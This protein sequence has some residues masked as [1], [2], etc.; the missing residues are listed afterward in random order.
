MK[1]TVATDTMTCQVCGRTIKASKG[2]IAHHGYTRP[3]QQGWQSASCL[4]ARYVPYEVSC[5]RLKE[6]AE[7]VRNYIVR[8]EE[9]LADFIA[10]PPE[11]LMV[12]ERVSSWKSPEDVTYHKPEGFTLK[13]LQYL[14]RRTYEDA[15]DDR[16]RG[17]EQSIKGA[18][19]D[20]VV[21]G[22]RI[23]EWKESK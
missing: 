9:T 17:Y 4:G 16:K 21:M 6:V 13:S 22:Q 14:R 3:Y 18:K 12:A 1:T 10:N 23:Q 11:T 5:E 20:L 2:L 19:S 7:I 15:Y 8:T